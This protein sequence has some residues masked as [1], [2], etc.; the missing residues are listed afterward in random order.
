MLKHI[1][2]LGTIAGI[3]TLVFVGGGSYASYTSAATV[4]N[5]FKTGTFKIDLTPNPNTPPS[6]SGSFDGDA[7]YAKTAAGVF[8]G[9]NTNVLHFNL[10]NMNPGS[11]Y[12]YT[13]NAYDAGSLQGEVNTVTYNPGSDASTNAKDLEGD[14]TI[15]VMNGSGDYLPLVSNSNSNSASGNETTAFN[16]NGY[17]G[18]YPDGSYFGPN[19]IQPEPNGTTSIDGSG[20]GYA[21]YTVVITYNNNGNQNSEEG[22]TINP[23]ITVS[24]STIN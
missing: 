20:E 6:V 1:A 16:T 3:A 4:D 17:K 18:I 15:Q 5:S 19:F 12:T 24:G 23:T 2:L 10:S 11:T 22:V 21:T 7:N 9:S 13:F 14:L 8:T